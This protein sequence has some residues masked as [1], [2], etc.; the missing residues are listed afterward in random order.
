MFHKAIRNRHYSFP[1]LNVLLGKANEFRSGDR[2]I[3][4]A[5]EDEKERVA[6]MSVLADLPL[7][8]FFEN[9][10]VPYEKDEVT[11]ISIDGIDA[12]LYGPI[13]DWTVAQLREFILGAAAK[14]VAALAWGL[15]PEMVAAVVKLCSN[16]DL[17]QIS[18]KLRIQSQAKTVLG[19]PGTLSS[20]LQ[21]NHPTDAVPGI[22]ALTLEGLAYGCGDCLIGVNPAIDSVESVTRIAAA[23]SD[24][25]DRFQ[26]P[27]CTCVLAHV[28]TQMKAVRA[29]AR[30]DI[31]FQSIAGTEKT[32]KQF[33]ITAAMLK[34]ARDLMVETKKGA[35][36]N[37]LY[38]ETGQGSELSLGSHEGCDQ[39]VLEARTYGVAR[40]FSP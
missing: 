35:Y 32:N 18:G 10:A 5:A 20:R 23:I 31:I 37:V 40:A 24:T 9:P 6:A 36:P 22:L 33:G 4:L 15:M 7:K 8:T 27:T 2:N 25:I 1:S 34:D 3:G 14:E 12:A 16:M 13:K 26:I 11:R 29:G 30:L 28:G 39:V 19:R 21:P 38:F 17:A